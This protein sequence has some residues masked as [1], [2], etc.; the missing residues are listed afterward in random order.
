[1]N[2]DVSVAVIHSD[3]MDAVAGYSFGEKS[4]E[5]EVGKFKV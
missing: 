4:F 5:F 3:S 2:N 1:V